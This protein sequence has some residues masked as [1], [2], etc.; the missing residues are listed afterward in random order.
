MNQ[1]YGPCIHL[2]VL[3]Y[4]HVEPKEVSDLNRRRSLA[5]TPEEFEA[6]LHY[7]TEHGYTSIFP[8]DLINF[9]DSNTPLPPKAVLLTFDDGYS[10]MFTHAFPL[11][12]KYYIKAALYLPTG[13]LTNPGYLNWDQISQMS[14]SGLI[15]FGN[16]TWSHKSTKTNLTALEFEITTATTQLAERNLNNPPT[17]VYPYG[18]VGNEAIPVLTKYNYKLA[19]TTHSGS[20]MCKQL[21]FLL[22]RIRATFKPL[23]TSGL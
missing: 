22:P 9:F 17:F 10:D 11:L 5:V 7:L 21:R 15:Y 14:N 18:S 6:H 3:Y 23:S 2:P 13:L 16:H 12:Q 19:F 20:V 4:H 1:L 8:A